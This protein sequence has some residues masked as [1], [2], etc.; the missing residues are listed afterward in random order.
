MELTA[1]QNDALTELINIGYARA[2]SALS[3]LTGHRISLEVPEVAIHHIAQ[4]TDKL[5]GVLE[6]EVASVN[7]VFSGPITGNAILLLDRAA[8]LLLNRLLTDRPDMT[9][10]DGA[11]REVITEV[12]NIV[13]NACLGAFGNLLKVQVTF[14]VPALQIESVQKVLRSITIHDRELEY[15]L[16]IRTSFHIKVSNVSGYLVI[17]LGV[18]SLDTLLRELKKWE[19]RELG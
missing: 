17:I 9:G 6:G 10:F 8:A 18:T 19:D 16:I 7:Q 13:L 5:Q 15:A 3:D 14:T 11:A 2:A 4:I 1:S 12:G